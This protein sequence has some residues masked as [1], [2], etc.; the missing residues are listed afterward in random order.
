MEGKRVRKE[1][2][3]RALQVTSR[4]AAPE[5]ALQPPELAEEGG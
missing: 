4:F 3:E 1:R 2:K 5:G